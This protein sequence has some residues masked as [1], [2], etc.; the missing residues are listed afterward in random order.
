MKQ[1]KLFALLTSLIIL[2]SAVCIGL[3]DAGL[4][5][6]CHGDMPQGEMIVA[7]AKAPSE[8]LLEQ[9]GLAL[10]GGDIYVA[11]RADALRLKAE[12][13]ELVRYIEDNTERKAAISEAMPDP[14]EKPYEYPMLELQKAHDLTKGDKDTVIAVLDTGVN[15]SDVSLYGAHILDGYDTSS[16]AAVISD[17]TGHGTKICSLIYT[18]APDCTIMPVK[19]SRGSSTIYTSDLIKGLHYAADNGAKIINLSFGGYNYSYAEQEAVDYCVSKGCI[20]IAAVGNDGMTALADQPNYPACYEGVIGIGSIGK[21]GQESEFSQSNGADIFAPGEMITLKTDDGVSAESGTS[22]SAA[23]ASATAALCASICRECRF[24]T[25]EYEFLITLCGTQ[26]PSTLKMIEASLYPAVTGVSD[27]TEYANDVYIYFNRGTAYLDGEEI[28]DGERVFIRGQH[29]LIVSHLGRSVTVSFSITSSGPEYK[30]LSQDGSTSILFEIGNAYLDGVPYASGTPITA[31]GEHYFEITAG[32]VTLSET[33]WVEGECAVFGV[34]DNASYKTPIT[35]YLTKEAML[36]GVAVSGEIFVGEGEHILAVGEREIRFAVS[37]KRTVYPPLGGSVAAD[38]GDRIAVFKKGVAGITLFDIHDLSRAAL[39]VST[40]EP[41]TDCIVTGGYAAVLMQTQIAV[42]DTLSGNTASVHSISEQC[43]AI[44]HIGEKIYYISQSTLFA[45]EDGVETALYTSDTKFDSLSCSESIIALY[46]STSD[47]GKIT[48]CNTA[49]SSVS[50]LSI[51]ASQ[52]GKKILLDEARLICG[53]HVFDLQSGELLLETDL[54]DIICISNNAYICKKGAADLVTGAALCKYDSEAQFAFCES[55]MLILLF[56]DKTIAETVS[57]VFGYG[58]YAVCDA[59]VAKKESIL[60]KSDITSV[61]NFGSGMLLTADGDR[62]VYYYDKN[63][64]TV[65]KVLP[66]VPEKVFADGEKVFLTFKSKKLLMLV[67]NG[68]ITKIAVPSPVEA[69]A[70]CDG[71]AFMLISGTLA[72]L[73]AD[74]AVLSYP[75][76]SAT[77]IAAADGRLITASRRNIKVFDIADMTMLYSLKCRDNAYSISVSQSLAAAGGTVFDISSGAVLVGIIGDAKA[78]AGDYLFVSGGIFKMQGEAL[79]SVSSFGISAAKALVVGG[80]LVAVYGTALQ[81]HDIS[82]LYLPELV[83]GIADGGVYKISASLTVNAG[84]AY[85]DGAEITGTIT[86]SD[87]GTHTLKV[88]LSPGIT[89]KYSFSVVPELGEIAFSQPELSIG[90]GEI[91]VLKMLFLP[92]GAESSELIFVSSDENV[93]TVDTHGTVTA[94]SPGDATVTAYTSDRALTA[95]CSIKVLEDPIR[96][97]PESGILVDRPYSTAYRIPLGTTVDEILLAAGSHSGMR[98]LGTDGAYLTEGIVTTGMR[99]ELYHDGVLHDAMTLSVVG[100]TDG[101]GYSTVLDLLMISDIISG[102]LSPTAAVE[103][104]ADVNMDGKVSGADLLRIRGQLLFKH[105]LYGDSTPPVTTATDIMLTAARHGDT[106][107]VLISTKGITP[108][109]LTGRLTFDGTKLVMTDLI[110]PFA[111]AEYRQTDSYVSFILRLDETAKN[112]LLVVRF[113]VVEDAEISLDSISLAVGKSVFSANT[114]GKTSKTDARQ[115]GIEVANALRG[116]DFDENVLEY[117][118]TL[119]KGSIMAMVSAPSNATVSETLVAG[120]QKFDMTVVM[121]GRQ[122]TLHC[123]VS[124]KTVPDSNSRISEIKADGARLVPDFKPDIHEYMLVSDSDKMP[125][126]IITAQSRYATVTTDIIGEVIT[127]VCTAEDGTQTVY[128]ITA[129]AKRSDTSS[130]ASSDT[131]T[132]QPNDS[133]EPMTPSSDNS[134]N[135][136]LLT[137]AIIILT[138]AAIAAAIISAKKK[139]R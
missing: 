4:V 22:Y 40:P 119:P 96:F 127:V 118:V 17:A 139:R 80:D 67:E 34:S 136:I 103:Y 83:S 86:V 28:D 36:D 53:R 124:D 121:N 110:A 62:N 87:G 115:S 61:C 44:C 92:F 60:F 76:V 37:D 43:I 41:V 134:L 137:V 68:D 138:L 11:S 65:F 8:K 7:L 94:V 9:Y 24:E 74:K 15:K 95:V 101:D 71:R 73:Q 107:D 100:D 84:L 30:K 25:G 33:F 108:D 21:D 59:F 51:D 16:G 1:K 70:F 52:L 99:I 82:A 55:E 131:G 104:A 116:I 48:L 117:N 31:E 106:L 46:D 129:E 23:F 130:E 39:F 27:K 13:G 12:Q 109:Y 128:T 69:M 120:R 3:S 5:F 42:F 126:L 2:L 79:V 38:A 63:Q 18:V 132:S 93:L 123:F 105:R 6:V 66:F 78:F 45:L 75:L 81:K 114:S 32:G 14:A 56:A 47:D 49:D 50:V 113:K 29:T 58:G 91:C 133:S 64:V 10:L 112:D 125:T 88:V 111:S 90:V 89:L 19:V 97:S 102:V 26:S 98:I 35:I 20:L 77:A 85:L 54:G 72:E 57:D 122:Y 135:I